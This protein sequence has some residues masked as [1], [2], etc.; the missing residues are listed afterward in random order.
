MAL[1]ILPF[2]LYGLFC[3]S[4][5]CSEFKLLHSYAVAKYPTPVF[6]TMDF[7]PSLCQPADR[8]LKKSVDCKISHLEFI[9]FPGTVFKIE[10]EGKYKNS[11]IYKVTTE[12]YPDVSGTGYFIDGRFVKLSKE[13]PRER[14]RKLPGKEKI[15][16]E[17]VSSQGLPY[18]WGGNFKSG[19]PE[20]LRF[21]GGFCL[22]KNSKK[23]LLLEGLDCSGL[24]YWATGGY[25][26]RNSKDLLK[27]GNPVHIKNLTA[28][29]IIENLKPLDLIV[30]D[31]HVIIILDRRRVIE[32][33]EYYRTGENKHAGGVRIRLLKDVLKE[34]LK[35]KTPLDDI[36]EIT[37]TGKKKFVIRRWYQL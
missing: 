18:L 13:K 23:K 25:T 24:L 9:A 37:K 27:Y 4:C 28:G 16:R 35:S 36:E 8:S 2:F 14:A 32:S 34:T 3:S 1:L 15:F 29:E 6:N 30:W 26:P 11:T 19:V 17:L 12:E 21:Y 31:G 10:A 22:N 7:I 5:F 20:M 33:R